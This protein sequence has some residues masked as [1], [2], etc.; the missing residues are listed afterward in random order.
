MNRTPP[1]RDFPNAGFTACLLSLLLSAWA[2]PSRAEAPTVADCLAAS[3]ASLK[4]VEQKQLLVERAQ[5]RICAATTCPTEISEE[6]LR[7]E[8]L[9]EARLA[10]VTFTT[11]AADA[12]AI[13]IAVDGHTDGDMKWGQPIFV[14]PHQQHSFTFTRSGHELSSRRLS[15]QP[16]GAV[17]Q[18]IAFAPIE[19]PHPPPVDTGTPVLRKVSWVAGGV[20]VAALGGSLLYGWMALSRRNAAREICPADCADT[21]GTKRWDDAVTAG[22]TSTALFVVGAA[23]LGTAIWAWSKSRPAS[24]V[25]VSLGPSGFS[26]AGS[27]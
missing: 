11:S 22:W 24:E 7:R 19:Q 1:S 9:V 25:Q 2:S 13:V 21:T 17:T 5:L 20:G 12:D 10:T 4:A 3:K 8:R 27:F 14:E 16:G 15:L 26:V 6:C 18:E 23:G